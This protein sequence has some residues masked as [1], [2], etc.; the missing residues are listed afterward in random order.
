M[1]LSMSKVTGR[2]KLIFWGVLVVVSILALNLI[3]PDNGFAARQ[4]KKKECVDCH[5][6][7][8]KTYMGLKN[9]HPGLQEGKCQNCHLSHG[10]VGKLLLVEEGNNLCFRCHEK[11][12]F[13]LDKK[14]KVRS[15]LLRGKCA[16]CHNPHASDADNL[17]TA[18]GPKMCYRCH[19]EEKYTKKVVHGIIAEQGCQA[20]HK[21]HYSEQPNLLTMAP[22]RLCRECHD[23]NDLTFKKAHGNYPVTKAACTTC[24]NPHSSENAGLLKASLHSPVAE[25]ECSACHQDASAK[26][27]FSLNAAAE[28]SAST[29]MIR[30]RSR[31]MEP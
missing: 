9:Q 11:A 28:K 24:H 30:G 1:E 31:A 19:A 10:I 3:A 22:E 25:G 4:F 18:E 5:G 26:D 29:A 2:L 6:E 17:L 20:C 23:S 21:P 27:P 16:S 13:N 14:T 12:E 8:S 7:F 15:A